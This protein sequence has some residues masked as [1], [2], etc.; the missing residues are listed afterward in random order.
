MRRLISCWCESCGSLTRGMVCYGE[1][2]GGGYQTIYRQSVE[3][4]RELGY[5]LQGG[6]LLGRLF[7]L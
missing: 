5:F 6:A 3:R 1:V 2:G 4:E 7:W